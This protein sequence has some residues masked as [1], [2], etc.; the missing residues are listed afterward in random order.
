MISNAEDS[1]KTE[2]SG[3]G[4]LWPA[5]LGPKAIGCPKVE[6]LLPEGD[7][8][9]KGDRLPFPLPEDSPKS[10]VET[11]FS[12]N[13]AAEGDAWQGDLLAFGV[14]LWAIPWAAKTLIRKGARLTGQGCRKGRTKGEGVCVW[15]DAGTRFSVV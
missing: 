5:A 11:R 10:A 6:S 4:E 8:C 9:A 14:L 12:G 2:D 13:L 7:N 3:P 15:Q 1:A